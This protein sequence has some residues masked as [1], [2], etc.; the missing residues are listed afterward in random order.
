MPD[1]GRPS[2]ARPPAAADCQG[3]DTSAAQILR[4]DEVTESERFARWR[5]WVSGT[6][7]PLECAPVSRQ[8]FNGVLAAWALGELRVSRVHADPHLAARTR[9]LIASQS[10][11]YDYFK[12]GLLTHGSCQLSQN[13]RETTL[14]PGDLAIYDCRRPYTMAFRERFAM[15]FL[16]FPCHRLRLPPAAI[17]QVLV[18]QVSSSES[19]CSLVA[20]FLRRLVT[21]LEARPDSVNR[22]LAD[23]VLDLLA[24]LF[25]EL[26]GGR[27]TDPAV[28]RR[29]LLLGVCAWIEANLAEPDL[30]P[31]AIADAHHISVRYLHR[32]FHD[33]G[34]SVARWVRER[35]L[36]N[37]RR[38]LEDPAQ[39]ERGVVTIARRWGFADPAY[40]SRIF[41]ASYGEP[42]GQYRLRAGDRL[43]RADLL[44]AGDLLGADPRGGRQLA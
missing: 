42:P 41:K 38:D 8:P 16:M 15:S 4:T 30:D 24:T 31:A 17:E 13:G 22:R 7:V 5:H 14:L 21:N 43:R 28:V 11:D 40:F 9:H 27:P 33:E 20:P 19:T 32:L 2:A 12:V 35:R 34:T 6:F 36:D 3:R 1:T 44:R 26:A 37:C 18:T 25:G 29:S 10:R 39:A 23:N